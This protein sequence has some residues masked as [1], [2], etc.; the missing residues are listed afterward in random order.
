M[1]HKFFGLVL[2]LDGVLSLFLPMDKHWKWQL[3]RLIRIGIGG[4]LLFS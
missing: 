4:C 1:L 3:G 2:I